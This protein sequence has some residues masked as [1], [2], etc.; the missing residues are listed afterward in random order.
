[1]GTLSLWIAFNVF[2]LLL[3]A[4]DLGVLHRH[5]KVVS[6]KEAAW[7]SVIWVA[8][9][10]VF[11]LSM[12]FWY[13]AGAADAA[14]HARG[15]EFFFGYVI[16]RA[17]SV[18]NIFVFL[19][20]FNYFGVES[21]YQY[22]VLFWGILGALLMRGA[23][24]GA[25][26]ALIAR[27]HWLLYVFGAFLVWTGAKMLFHKAEEVHPE[28][29]P[30]LRLARRLLPITKNYEGEQFFVHRDGRWLA[31]PLFLVLLVVETTDVAFALDSIPAIF[32]ITRD[33]FVIYSS[34]VFAILGLRALYFLLAGIMPYFRYLSAGL[35][36]VLMFIGAKML[37]EPWLE[38]PIL[39]SLGIVIGVLVFAVLASLAAT[40]RERRLPAK[41]H[42]HGPGL[43]TEIAGLVKELGSEDPAE[44][45][46]AA[47]ALYE[48]G[49]ALG[50]AAIEDWWR[51]H[52]LRGLV[53][54]D[55]TVGI[56]V[57]PESFERVRASLGAPPLAEVPP[58]QDAQEF[59]IHFGPRVK[60]DIL[61]T[62]AP[63]GDG[64]IA[65][66][67]A[68]S[69]EGI[70]QV[71]F[72]TLNVDH[73]TDLLRTRLGVQP[74]YPATHPGA[75]GTRVNFVLAKTPEG[76]KVL[77]ELVEKKN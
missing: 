57:Q 16:E 27:F 50:E 24:I 1:M 54:R 32:G 17:L 15:L 43:A 74:V 12:L 25:G 51:D 18:D 69:G 33:P 64:A 29:N 14:R 7:W 60:L 70:Q 59:E 31:T 48:I 5:A 46:A 55:S 19:V 36:L 45:E 44:Q 62:R 58:D 67:L 56:A 38:I 2:V 71:E 42:I 53:G 68:K 41:V 13:P 61:T 35:S 40:L 6:L 72:P 10:L 47:T 76:K 30:V 75:N 20:L 37:A 65:R 26:V 4:L 21:R 23:M 77:V 8:V 66:F 28:H 3:L 52:D 22:R 11:N 63:G 34:N 39:P 73:A 9:A 49:H